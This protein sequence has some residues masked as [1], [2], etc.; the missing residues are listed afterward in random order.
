[1]RI[2]ALF[3]LLS[4]M[5]A[6]SVSP[7]ANAASISGEVFATSDGAPIEG[8]YI[9]AYDAALS[10]TYTTTDAVGRWQLDNLAPGP[11]RLRAVTTEDQNYPIRNYPDAWDFCEGERIVLQTSDALDGYDFSLPDGGQFVGTV[12]D[13]AGTPVT[14]AYVHVEG[15][16]ERTAGVSVTVQADASGVFVI[17]GLDAEEDELGEY[18]V[19]LSASNLPEQY[20]PGTYLEDEADIV[21]VGLGE[22]VGFGDVYMLD[23]I[24]VSGMVTGPTNEPVS[25]AEVFVYSGGMDWS[26][27]I[28]T[29]TTDVFGTYSVGALPPGYVLSWG[30]YPGLGDTYY[31]D[32]DRPGSSEAATEE[33][34]HLEGLNLTMPVESVFQIQVDADVDFSGASGLLY[35]DT[36][37][38]GHGNSFQADGTLSIDGLRKGMYALYVYAKEEGYVSDWVRDDAG[39]VRWFSVEDNG[40]TYDFGVISL[41]YGVVFEGT[42]Q[43]LRGDPI[44]GAT[45]TATDQAGEQWS[46]KTDSTGAFTLLGLSEGEFSL[47]A[48]VSPYCDADPGYAPAWWLGA[49]AEDDALWI[50]AS[51]GDLRSGFILTMAF[52]T[53]RDDM[54]D[55]WE[56]DVGLDVG[57]DDG[58]EDP[59][60]DGR[61][62]LEEWQDDTD[63]FVI[64]GGIRTCGCA[65]S[66]AR[67]SNR[68]FAAF[69]LMTWFGRRRRRS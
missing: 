52:D 37:T 22:T 49:R 2:D 43:D 50:T 66:P 15:I 64:D 56:S 39:E 63:P 10:Y 8:V 9:V 5:V 28:V 14:D 27:Q 30:T 12:L 58:A 65:A 32:A 51:E 61:T 46:G 4:A 11:I 41:P 38:V 55:Q 68:L 24:W 23:G 16:S 18:I 6:W 53:D 40:G 62:N 42:V 21:S 36:Y 47:K 67:P 7:N 26:G 54:G 31:P 60:A 69:A 48:K 45:V 33:A 34:V 35:N 59:D 57:R 20:A 29:A 25:G 13:W 44:Y 1:M 17:S 3:V 19:E